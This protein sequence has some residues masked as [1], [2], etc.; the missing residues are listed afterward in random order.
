MKKFIT[1][2]LSILLLQQL[3]VAQDSDTPVMQYFDGGKMN[4]SF[5]LGL[6]GFGGGTGNGNF[7]GVISPSL[8]NGSASMFYNPAGLGFLKS[9]EFFFDSKVSFSLESFGAGKDDVISPDMIKDGLDDVLTDTATFIFPEENYRR[10]TEVKEADLGQAG[11]I[12]AFGIAVPV[13]KNIT[14]GLGYSILADVTMDLL[15]SGISTDLKTT[16]T[17]GSEETEI[18][19]VLRNSFAMNMSLKLN[20][21]VFSTGAEIFNDNKGHL[22]A[23][24]SAVRYSA[25]EYLFVNLNTTGMM[26]LDNSNEY[27][28]NNPNDKTLNSEAGERNDLFWRASGNY[29]TTEWGF[30]FGTFYQYTDKNSFLSHFKFSL[31]YDNMPKLT[32]VDENAYSESYQPKFLTGK[33]L[34]EDD[35]ALD[36]VVDS[37]EITKPHLTVPTNNEFSDSVNISFPSSLL[38]GID[39]NFG[40]HTF[41]LNIVKYFDELSYEFGKYKMGLNASTGIKAGF[42]F[43]FPEELKGWAWALLPVRLLYLDFDGLLLQAFQA[44]TGYSDPH[45]R[46]GGGLIM[47]DPIVEGFS[48]EA[49]KA[50]L[51]SAL[52]S[53]IPTGFALGR[54]YTVLEN[55][56]VGV[57]VFG[58]PNLAL[59][60]SFSYRL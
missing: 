27:Y 6:N 42:D 34:G 45:Y 50:D 5:R 35:D 3:L 15:V 57:L 7:G 40:D 16:K 54:S 23:G 8:N 58:F 31:I 59:K 21:L 38:L 53:G 37:I 49:Q 4:F 60:Y 26:I 13:T 9:T 48:D 12:T 47:G 30:K 24:I 51:E 28:F 41:A 29:E 2:I 32:M 20:Q 17:V 22:N 33:F 18:D 43:K 19:I 36:F 14:A 11:G 52:N 39:A 25:G 55:L 44:R 56:R 1:I 10:D 46:V